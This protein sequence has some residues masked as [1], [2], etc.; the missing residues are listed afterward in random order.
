M[1]GDDERKLGVHDRRKIGYLIDN[2][3]FREDRDIRKQTYAEPDGNRGLDV[4][5]I[6]TGV[7]DMPCPS[8]R[9]DGVDQPVAIEASLFRNGDWN[10]IAL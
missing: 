9:F 5:Q 10:G 3:V 1:L 6:R 4:R 7:G 2:L 8:S